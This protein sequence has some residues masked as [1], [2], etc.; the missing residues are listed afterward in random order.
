MK[1][2][3]VIRIVLLTRFRCGQYQPINN[4]HSHLA[5]PL[6]GY[7][8]LCLDIFGESKQMAESRPPNGSHHFVSDVQ[9][10]ALHD[11]FVMLMSKNSSIHYD[12]MSHIIEFI[13]MI[14]ITILAGLHHL[15]FSQCVNVEE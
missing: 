14:R 5:V 3:V 15:C 8:V 7:I 11:M 4:S 9:I 13:V 1:C 6:Y 12:Q 10:Y 2:G